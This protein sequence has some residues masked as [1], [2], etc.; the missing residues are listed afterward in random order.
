MYGLLS[1]SIVS[2][3]FGFKLFFFFN[4][5]WGVLEMLLTCLS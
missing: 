5:F 2:D 3:Y 4:S 1:T